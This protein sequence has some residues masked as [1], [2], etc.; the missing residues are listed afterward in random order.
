MHKIIITSIKFTGSLEFELDNDGAV[1]VYRNLAK[2][3]PQQV[4]LLHKN[5]PMDLDKINEL[6]RSYKTMKAQLV[7]LEI[8]FEM[9]WDRYGLKRNKIRTEKYWKRLSVA[10]RLKAW[11]NIPPYFAYLDR[12]P[13]QAKMYPDTY[14]NPDQRK[15]ENEYV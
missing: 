8:T 15:F 13:N 12:N 9:F 2:L 11:N 10:D 6:V 7:E 1:R 4:D 5:F 14:L 3:N